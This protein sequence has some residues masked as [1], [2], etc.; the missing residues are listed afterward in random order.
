MS[1]GFEVGMGPRDDFENTKLLESQNTIV[2]LGMT[3]AMN[4]TTEE[5][6]VDN[7]SFKYN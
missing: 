1:D 7:I 2:G 5:Q 3:V 4:S 6:V